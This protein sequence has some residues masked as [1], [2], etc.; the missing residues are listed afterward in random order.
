ML[1]DYNMNIPNQIIQEADNLSKEL[2]LPFRDCLEILVSTLMGSH[3]PEVG[4][5]LQVTLQPVG[6]SEQRGQEE[7]RGSSRKRRL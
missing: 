1:Y 4:T 3:K 2:G 5:C 6:I 7:M